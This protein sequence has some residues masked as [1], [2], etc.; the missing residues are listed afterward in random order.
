MLVDVKDEDEKKVKVE[1]YG[2]EVSRGHLHYQ[3]NANLA[4]LQ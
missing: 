2:N 4:V 1:E 3:P